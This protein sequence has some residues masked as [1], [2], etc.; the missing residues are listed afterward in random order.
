VRAALKYD[1][2]GDVA[3]AESTPPMAVRAPAPAAPA[4]A[5]LI[6]A[7][8]CVSYFMVILDNSIVFTGCRGSAST[9]GS[10]RM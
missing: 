3:M 1:G 8:I 10:L 7:I 5:A 6:L 9:W 4:R 2:T